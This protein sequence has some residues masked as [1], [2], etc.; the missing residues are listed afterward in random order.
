MRCTNL[1]SYRSR[2]PDHAANPLRTKAPSYSSTHSNHSLQA[3]A[4]KLRWGRIRR[5]AARIG[6]RTPEDIEAGHN[7]I[8]AG[9]IDTR[10]RIIDRVGIAGAG[11][12]SV[13]VVDETAPEDAH[14]RCDSALAVGAEVRDIAQDL[15]LDWFIGGVVEGG[16]GDGEE[17]A[18]GGRE[19]RG[20]FIEEGVDV[21]DVVDPC[22][23]AVEDL[24][25]RGVAY[26]DPA[27]GAE[28]G[29]GGIIGGR[30]GGE[31]D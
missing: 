13:Q 21:V 1:I 3:S 11:D 27:S 10:N 8:A 15:E 9:I 12:N 7:N 31:G 23:D 2:T 5:G 6:R 24:L 26:L 29:V 20:G 16:L 17:G 4:F 14:Q 28:G 25:G 19:E 22:V 18:V 30:C